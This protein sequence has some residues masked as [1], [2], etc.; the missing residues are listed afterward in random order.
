MKVKDLKEALSEHPDDARVELG[1]LIA[2]G[3]P[4]SN[5]AGE[6]YELM[7]DLPIIGLAHDEKGGDLR[8][9]VE[10]GPWLLKFGKVR[11]LS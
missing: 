8:L 11:K 7:L 5:E 9:V 3:M 1:K 6:S 4:G 2:V 10:A